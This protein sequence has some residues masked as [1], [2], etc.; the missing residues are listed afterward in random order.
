[1]FIACLVSEYFKFEHRFAKCFFF[2]RNTSIELPNVLP[3]KVEIEFRISKS[4]LGTT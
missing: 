2:N 4:F 1:M 3:G